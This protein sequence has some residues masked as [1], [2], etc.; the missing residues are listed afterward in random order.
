M[1]AQLFAIAL[2]A[3]L[4][5]GISSADVITLEPDAFAPGTNVTYAGPGVSLWTVTNQYVLGVSSLVYSPVY[6]RSNPTCELNPFQCDAV[7]GT[8]GF[9]PYGDG[10]G[11]LYGNY[12]DT[13]HVSP[14][15]ASVS[16]PT[17]ADI[18]NY[19]GNFAGQSALL[20]A[21]DGTADYV[22]I[23]TSWNNDYGDIVAYD[24]SFNLIGSTM[25]G[26]QLPETTR[27]NQSVLS[28]A[29]PN[30]KYVVAGSVGDAIA[31]DT[32]RY[33]AVPEPSTL[34]LSGLGFAALVRA[35]R[36]SRRG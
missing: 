11:T 2:V 1:R 36:R 33:N 23:A 15:F 25:Y 29:A 18:G 27:Y 16:D 3:A 19:C 9:S 34:L 14:C 21:F 7:T 20:M 13:S 8:Q 22:E 4:A 31:I 30:M 35:R 28:L 32:I 24:E 12:H 5:P 17:P 26:T 6:V 10:M